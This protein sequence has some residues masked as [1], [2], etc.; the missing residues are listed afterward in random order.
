MNKEAKY[1]TDVEMAAGKQ[2]LW[3]SPF[4]I[5]ITAHDVLEPSENTGVDM[6][7]T[8]NIDTPTQAPG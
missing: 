3:L 5:V 4:T 2:G 6:S 7:E 1:I 8:D